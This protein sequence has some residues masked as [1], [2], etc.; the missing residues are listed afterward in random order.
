MLIVRIHSYITLFVIFNVIGASNTSNNDKIIVDQNL[1]Y[2]MGPYAHYVNEVRD[3]PME[4]IGNI[5]TWLNGMYYVGGS[6][7]LNFADR[8]SS[9]F[10]DALGRIYRFDFDGVNQRAKWSGTTMVNTLFNE[11]QKRDGNAPPTIM[12]RE[13]TPP[14]EYSTRENLFA[15]ADS[16][17]VVQ[18]QVGSEMFGFTDDK[19]VTAYSDDF[20]FHLVEFTDHIDGGVTDMGTSVAHVIRLEDSRVAV[21]M[22]TITSLLPFSKPHVV[23]Y[24]ISDDDPYTR[25]EIVRFPVESTPY[26]HSFGLSKRHALICDHSWLFD[27]DKLMEG[28][29]AIDATVIDGNESTKLIVVNL[30][31]GSSSTYISPEPF[32]C[33]HFSNLYEIEDDKST[34][35]V[36]EMPTWQ[37]PM[38]RRMEV[39]TAC[40]PYKIFDFN[41][42]V[43]KTLLN[44]FNEECVN[45]LVQHSIKMFH[46]DQDHHEVSFEVLDKGWYE[47]PIY[48]R[49]FLGRQSCFLY[50][51]EYYHNGKDFG[52]IA[53]VK[54]NTCEKRRAAEWYEVAQYPSEPHFVGSPEADVDEDN[55][56]IITPIMDGIDDERKSYFL[57]LDAKDFTELARMPMGESVPS[58]VHGWFKFNPSDF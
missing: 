24:S 29:M 28:K 4:I 40:N 46:D 19:Y 33:E 23:L 53:I 2:F 15:V 13:T 12:F 37:T 55:G 8:N 52:S 16:D 47:Y 58:T 43:N 26:Q 41:R 10:L 3:M 21:G 56:V 51:V 39:E 34:T 9:H 22:M 14:R 31:D 18:T 35:L 45:T 11:T 1:E 57:I 6:H 36:F 32:L 48:N 20:Q 25:Q 50:L 7:Y 42:I 38:N 44:S 27:S 5:P 49:K 30:D 54:Y 17:Y